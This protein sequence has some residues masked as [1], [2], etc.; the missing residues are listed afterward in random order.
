[1]T[2]TIKDVAREAKVSIATV[3]RVFNSSGSVSEETRQ[4]IR[5]VAER[6]R[7]M[8]HHGARSLITRR[9]HLLGV[10]L[11]EVYGEFFS[12]LIRGIDLS[13]RKHG[14]HI[15]VSGSHGNSDE[16][17]AA[18]RVMQGRVDGLLAML[19]TVDAQFL[20]TSLPSSM[21]VVLMN[22][23]QSGQHDSSVLIDNFGGAGELVRHL[24]GKGYRRIAFVAGPDSNFDAR[25]RL[26]GYATT[27]ASLVPDAERQVIEGDFTEESGYQAGKRI[28]AMAR[29]PDAIFAANDSMAIGCL[30]ALRE[31]GLKVPTDIA[32]A[33]FDDIPIARFVNPPLTTVRVRIAELG[34]LALRRLVHAISHPDSRAEPAHLVPCELVVRE[35]CAKSTAAEAAAEERAIS[36][37]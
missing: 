5:V 37:N 7:Y 19:P 6:L 4:R 12:E 1:M 26:R 9:T 22:T 15:L 8:P 29:R 10:I 35:S 18:I 2:A 32:L 25:E 20:S 36:G 21:P 11:P 27:L 33:G 14:L 17:A 30:F 31:A 13:A 24:V 3:S 28:A 34:E 16:A 23:P